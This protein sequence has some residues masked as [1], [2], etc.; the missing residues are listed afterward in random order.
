MR[1]CTDLAVR[2]LLLA[3][4][5]GLVC[6]GRRSP[7]IV[8]AVAGGIDA[9]LAAHPLAAG[10][11]LRADEIPRTPGASY[12]L[13]QVRGAESPHRHRAHDLAVFVLRGE[14]MLTLG[15]TPTRLHTGDA[16]VIPRDR[17]HWFARR[18]DETAVALVVFSPAL[19]APDIVPDSVDAI[20]GRQ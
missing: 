10:Q 1:G 6:G 14:G 7:T 18:G 3:C 15:G 20:P 4:L 2:T 12:P 8:G 5:A 17:G 19:D 11:P 16:A 9:F 13:V